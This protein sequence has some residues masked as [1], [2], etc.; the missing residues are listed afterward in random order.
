MEPLTNNP[1]LIV[2]LGPTASGKSALAME[3]AERFNGEIIA[4]DSRT[5]YKGMDIGTAKPS[6]KEQRRIP[7]HL[8][9]VVSPDEPFTVADF[10]RLARQAIADIIERG[11]VPIMVGGTGLYIDAVIYNFSFRP[12]GKPR[13]RKELEA[14]AIEE[15]Q[16]RLTEEGIELPANQQNPRHLIRTLETKGAEPARTDLRPNTL[17]IGLDIAKATLEEKITQRTEQMVQAGLEEEV[18]RLAARYGWSTPALLA[19]A[20]KAFRPFLAGVIT[21][22]EA[23]QSFVQQDLQYAKRQKTWFK[24]S[25]DIHWISEPAESVALITTFLNK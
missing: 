12:P 15:L 19:P 7:H 11:H 24:R 20:Y 10:Q 22:D 25:K 3:L 21:L 16:A 1:P 8:I 23:K 9:D 17:V 2:I 13:L 4:A 5:V 18:R 6:A 14:L